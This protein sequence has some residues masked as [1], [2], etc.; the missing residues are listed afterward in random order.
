MAGLTVRLPLSFLPLPAQVLF[1]LLLQGRLDAPACDQIL[2]G[3]LADE[4]YRLFVGVGL[5]AALDEQFDTAPVVTKVPRRFFLRRDFLFPSLV[6]PERGL[7]T[8]IRT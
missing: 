8:P 7:L 4:G 1:D 2:V 5:F 3:D 6:A